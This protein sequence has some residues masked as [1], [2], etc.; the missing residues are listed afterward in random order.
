MSYWQ[1]A[2]DFILTLAVALAF[3]AAAERFRQ[4]AILGYLLA[5]VVSGPHGFGL[6]RNPERVHSIAEFGVVLLLFAIGLEFSI[7]RLRQL[8]AAALWGGLLQVVVTIVVAALALLAIGFAIAPAVSFAAMIAMSSTACV[9]RVLLDRGMI[10]SMHGRF[11][12]GILLMQDVAVI[13]LMLLLLVL[14]GGGAWIDSVWLVGRTVL[15]G[16]VLVVLLYVLLKFIVPKVLTSEQLARNR[17]LPILLAVVLAMG[18][19]GAAEAAGV[20]PA[21]GAFV[22]GVLLG[23]SP[24][25]TQIRADVG[26]LRTVLVTLFFASIGMLA[27]PNWIWQNGGTVLVFVLLVLVGKTVIVWLILRSL[28]LP[29]GPALATGM[30]IA[31][32]GEFS[33][34]LAHSLGE[35]SALD[36][37]GVQ[38]IAAACLL[39]LLVTPFLIGLAPAVTARLHRLRPVRARVLSE[40]A[41]E[42]RGTLEADIEAT[43]SGN[44][45]GHR[46]HATRDVLIIGFGPAGHML[47]ATLFDEY[48]ERILILDL[49]ARNAEAA[50]LFGLPFVFGDAT[51]VETLQ[52]FGAAQMRVIAVTVPDPD[53]ARRVLETCRITAPRAHIFVRSRYHNRR[54][55]LL[56]A[57]AHEVVDEEQEVGFTMADLIRTSL[58]TP[59]D[60]APAGG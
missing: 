18:S 30:C 57:G 19:A 27:D 50:T 58:A 40:W 37:T 2:T 9:L 32:V 51:H 6:V 26:S 31:Q 10:D 25:A 38:M 15:G 20:S 1:A 29:D 45:D 34:V 44:E 24:F 8:G 52:H 5:G 28:R 60:D 33:F 46:T 55:E 12:V 49:N 53:I 14:N 54:W 7:P 59:Q 11:S 4:S 43:A 42:G 41:S 21:L 56:L 39:S 23:E 36:T 47:A 13:P 48:S 22:A 3:G 17:E 35:D 16:T